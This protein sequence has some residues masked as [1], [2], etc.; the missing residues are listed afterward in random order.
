MKLDK[1]FFSYL[2]VTLLLI[3]SIF[4]LI[5]M[6]ADLG[7]SRDYNLYRNKC[8][9]RF[10]YIQRAANI[11]LHWLAT[12]ALDRWLNWLRLWSKGLGRIGI[13]S[14]RPVS[15]PILLLPPARQPI[16]PYPVISVTDTRNGVTHT[17]TCYISTHTAVCLSHTLH[18]VVPFTHTFTHTHLHPA[19]SR[20]VLR[21][22]DAAVTP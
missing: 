11:S 5:I 7:I 15:S 20:N 6:A 3:A 17:R 9:D 14:N 19:H 13:W 18:Q 2:W 1:E 8:H 16:S 12:S 10:V 21:W 22:N 4:H